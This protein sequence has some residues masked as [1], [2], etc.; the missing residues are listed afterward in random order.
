MKTIR[1]SLPKL[2]GILVSVFLTSSFAFGDIVV[3]KNGEA[4]RGIV[5]ERKEKEVILKVRYGR[6][7]F[8]VENIEDIISEKWVK[9]GPLEEI[10]EDPADVTA[11]D[12]EENQGGESISAEEENPTEETIRSEGA[13]SG[14]KVGA[15][16]KTIA[17]LKSNRPDLS[18]RVK[19][20]LESPF[21]DGLFSGLRIF[22]PESHSSRFFFYSFIFLALF[23]FY[24]VGCKF[25]NFENWSMGKCALLTVI[26][27]ILGGINFMAED[28]MK[29][30]VTTASFLGVGFIL[31]VLSIF[32]IFQESIVKTILM[33]ISFFFS[34]C[35]FSAFVFLILSTIVI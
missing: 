15:A 3:L 33:M 22:L 19:E 25:S 2:M 13:G 11:G 1:T 4:F 30:V 14:E 12:L 24:M 28:A 18:E 6:I 20:F 7:I 26:S 29:G 34:F 16:G 35:L 9:E 5:V 17:K 8:D 10:E 23:F 27:F 32:M 31:W 21:K